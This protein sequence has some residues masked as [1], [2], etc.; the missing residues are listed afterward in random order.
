M[1]TQNLLKNDTTQRLAYILFMDQHHYSKEH[2]QLIRE[3]LEHRNYN[4]NNQSEYLYIQYFTEDLYPGWRKEAKKMFSELSS[5]GWTY[6]QQIRYKYSW[7]SFTM[8][9]FRVD[10]DEKLHSILD[11]YLE[12]FEITC[13]HCGS[14]K[15]VGRSLDEPLCKKC[16]LNKLKKKRIRN[17]NTFGFTYYHKKF[18]HILWSEIKKVDL[19]IDYQ[20]YSHITLSRLTEKEEL[21]KGYHELNSVFFSD[22]SYNFFKLLIKIPKELLTDVQYKEIHALCNHLKKCIICHRKSV[23]DDHCFICRSTISF[24]E[25]PT[26]KNL[27]RFQSKAGILKY[28]QKDFKRT[29]E[30]W[31]EY[32]YRY[33]TD[34]FFKSK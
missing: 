16:T 29:L 24:V 12:I 13:S 9:G 32:R 10:V 8:R 33:E 28:K 23:F 6:L 7:G 3:E 25:Y 18:H 5:N 14:Q 34:T 20:N 21:E 31:S 27:E 26:P 4:F 19:T 1:E 17:I 22:R 2:I 30:Y 11:K 15:N